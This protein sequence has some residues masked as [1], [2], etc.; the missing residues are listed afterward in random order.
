MRYGT[1]VPNFGSFA[2]V[3]KTAEM[4]HDAE[5]AGWDGFFVWDHISAAASYD[6]KTPIA[7]EYDA[8]HVEIRWRNV[9]A[10]KD[11]MCQ[12]PP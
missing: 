6:D 4:A 10:G 1:S 3:R 7:L 12:P 5:R 8:K 2:D 9:V 11:V